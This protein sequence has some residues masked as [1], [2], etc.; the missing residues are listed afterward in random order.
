MHSEVQSPPPMSQGQMDGSIESKFKNWSQVGFCRRG[1]NLAMRAKKAGNDWKSPYSIVA[2]DA[3][4][5]AVLKAAVKSSLYPEINFS[6]DIRIHDD[7][8]VRMRMDEVG[9]LRKRYDETSSWALVSE[10]T[11]S[12]T[13]KWEEGKEDVR[14]S[15]GEKREFEIEVEYAP[16]KVKLLRGGKDQVVLN[17]RGLLHM[18]HFRTKQVKEAKSEES[19]VAAAQAHSSTKPGSWF[20]GDIEDDLWEE[21]F[22][23]WTD[24]KP[25]GPESLS[26]DITFP[27]HGTVYGIPQH[28][29]RLALP[30]TTG[31]DPAFSDPYRLYNN[32]VYQYPASSA[33]SLYGSI[34]VMHAQSLD[35]T[36][37]LFYAT[38][39]ETWIDISHPSEDAT[40]THW[41]SESGILDLFLMPGPTPEKVF[42]QYA[43]LTGTTP[44]PAHWSLGYH[45]CRW[46]YVSSDDIRMV[47][48]RF[49]EEDMPLDVL[50]LDIEYSKDHQYF[51]WDEKTFPD[52]LDMINE[53][54]SNGRKMVVI[55]DPHLQRASN[56]PVYKQASELGLLVRNKDNGEYEG[57]CWPGSSS[58]VD[59]FN[60]AS[61]EWWKLLFK[62]YKLPDGQ[63]SWTEST[64]DVHIWNDM[65]EPAVFDGPE[66]TMPKDNIHYGGWEHRDVHNLNGMTYAKATSQ[67][68]AARTDP[69]QRP[70]VLTRSFFAGAH[71]YAAMWTGDNKGKWEHM[72]IGIK[73][74]LANGIAGMTFCGSDVG[75]FFGDPEPEM[76]VRWY[77]VGIFSPFFRAH[78]QHNTKRREPYLLKEPFKGMVKDL[79]KLRYSM[80]P[81]WYTG[82]REASVN[83]LPVLRPQYVVFPKDKKGFEIDDQY[84]IAGSGLLVKPV[85]EAGAKQASVYLAEEQVY[86]D[87]FT[88]QVHRGAASGKSVTV[89]AALRQVPLLIRGGSIVPTRE[90]PRKAS[91]FMKYDPF[92][93]RVALDKDGKARGE[94]YLDDGV[95]Y[96]YQQGEFVW[97]EFVAEQQPKKQKNGPLLKVS[98]RDLGSANLSE[99]VQNIAVSQYDPENAYAKDMADV[100]VEKIVIVGLSK[101]P[102]SVKVEETGTVLVWQF[103]SGMGSNEQAKRGVV[104]I[105]TLGKGKKD[106]ASV[107]TIQEPKLPVAKEW[108]ISIY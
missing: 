5:G 96:N 30:T 3:N 40:E 35:S 47:Q 46:N 42:K 26:I 86:Y 99:S 18:E 92:T 63:W 79:L 104:S 25:K 49:D 83:G 12:K 107:L 76:L 71:R 4:E 90:R 7:G 66:V 103:V 45:Q 102:T 17:G 41:I 10:P 55:V 65:N 88:Y 20:E 11:I 36:I 72:A 14:A 68:V 108:T 93:L 39:S 44:L 29:T 61:S 56:Y 85:A 21:T 73:M 89:P 28:A 8:V 24:T 19:A 91:S 13:V 67:A 106:V 101:K 9:G 37:G 48:K 87:Y 54:V 16:L 84:Y 82:F 81:I 69:S 94:L 1:R 50:W 100:H 98:N 23:S 77:Q 78:A 51:I 34:P 6:L 31:E 58:W 59:F 60:P 15:F 33:L 27:N 22:S 32:D 43:G 53:I 62:P 97:R 38:A 2:V 74:V 95:S 70:F 57:S 64:T 105:L 80:L 75:G 52:P